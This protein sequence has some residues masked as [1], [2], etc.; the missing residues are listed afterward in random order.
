MRLTL[1]QPSAVDNFESILDSLYDMI[2][3]VSGSNTRRL[4]KALEL[5]GMEEDAIVEKVHSQIFPSPQTYD[6]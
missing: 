6:D 5:G 1:G 2:E 4:Q 3:G